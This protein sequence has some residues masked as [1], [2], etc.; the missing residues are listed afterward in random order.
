MRCLTIVLAVA[1]LLAANQAKAGE[2]TN[3]AYDCGLTIPAQGG[4]KND[5]ESVEPGVLLA[6]VDETENRSLMVLVEDCPGEVIDSDSIA[7]IESGFLEE[8]TKIHGRRITMGGLP[9][10]ELAGRT[11]IMGQEVT[12]IFRTVIG[13]DRLYG[14]TVSMLGGDCT[15]D[16]LCLDALAG[17]RFLHPPRAPTKS[18]LRGVAGTIGGILVIALVIGAKLFIRRAVSK[19]TRPR[20]RRR[21]TFGESTEPGEARRPVQFRSGTGTRRRRR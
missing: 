2:W 18:S 8:M 19:P 16:K 7:E 12:T 21:G 1:G 4:W 11:T 14:V 15:T 20:T 10:Y 17:F 13:N 6:L 3:A 5:P 9:A